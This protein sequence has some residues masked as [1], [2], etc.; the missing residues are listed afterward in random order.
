MRK[1][2]SDRFA[3][4]WEEDFVLYSYSKVFLE[5]LSSPLPD[6]IP[7]MEHLHYADL[8]SRLADQVAI[9]G[10]YAMLY[11]LLTQMERNTAAN[12]HAEIAKSVIENCHGEDFI[13]RLVSSFPS[14]GRKN[15]GAVMMVC[16]HYG[17][18][19]VPYL[20]D[21]LETEESAGTRKFLVSLFV[22][23]G[24]KVLKE[25]LRRL[26]DR[27]WYVRRNILY[28]L[29]E[30]TVGN[31][32]GDIRPYCRD[33]DP[34]VRLEAARCLVKT[35]DGSGVAVLRELIRSGGPDVVE[36]AVTIAGTLKVSELLPDLT[37]ILKKKM[38]RRSD[39]RQKIAAVKAIGQIGDPRAGRALEE[40]LEGHSILYPGRM[41]KLKEAARKALHS[42]TSET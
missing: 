22:R 7:P 8:F 2:G 39:C 19:I 30:S 26:A 28:I 6:L 9:T 5:V 20:F 1:E 41:K 25:S 27:R 4:E 21:I 29:G 14:H 18:E 42:M 10:Q 36:P 11:D 24:D 15:R 17:E 34:R 16:E 33:P 32:P 23:L 12:V 35:G 38:V 3:P 37:G 31:R 40:I 13:S